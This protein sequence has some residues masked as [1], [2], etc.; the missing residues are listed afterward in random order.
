M[1]LREKFQIARYRRGYVRA[2]ARNQIAFQFRFQRKRSKMTQ[3]AVAEA[4][5]VSP[6]TVR[7]LESPNEPF[8]SLTVLFAVADVLGLEISFNLEP[9]YDFVERISLRG[10]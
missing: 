5:G 2:N 3:K 10:G 9:M 8:P 1:K 7:Q 4:A 6:R